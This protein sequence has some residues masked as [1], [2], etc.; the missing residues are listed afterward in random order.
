MK[1]LGKEG[2]FVQG[3]AAEEP[4]LWLV[5]TGC[6]VTMLSLEVYNQ[7]PR[8]D[9]PALSPFYGNLITGNGSVMEVAGQT[10]MRIAVDGLELEHDII[11]ADTDNQG[12]LGL[13]FM[14]QHDAVIN[15][16]GGKLTIG[17]RVVAAECKQV[18]RSASRVTLAETV[19]VPAGHRM[20]LPG[21]IGGGVLAEGQ[22]MIGPL[23][24]TPGNKAIA[25]A[26]TL[27]DG[28]KNKVPFE[29]MNP[30]TEDILLYKG[31]HVALA[32]PAE[33]V[34]DVQP[35]GFEKTVTSERMN[36]VGLTAELPPELGRMVDEIGDSVSQGEKRAI[37]QMLHRKRS[38][39]ML[40]G[41]PLGK[42]D[43]VHHEIH[44]TTQ[45]PIKQPARRFPIHQREEGEKQVKEM[46]EK[47]LIEPSESPWASPV[48]LVKKKDGSTRF[49]IDYRRLNDV[50][51]KD[52]YPLPRIDD[53]LDALSGAD[54]FSTLDLASGYWQVGLAD[55]ARQK[56][57]FVTNSGLYQFTVMPFGLSNAPST[58]ERLMERVLSGLQWQICL[59]YLDDVIVFSR[60]VSQ[61]ISRLEEVLE[62]IMAA[63]LRLKP[64]KCHLFQTRVGYLGHVVSGEGISTDPE[65]IKA[66]EDW[67]VPK[68]LHDV[69]SFLGLCS[70]Y[71][72]FI[73]D[74]SSIAKPLTQL[75]EKERDFVWGTAQEEAWLDL[76]RR[77]V[78]APILAYPDPQLSFILDTDASG[79]GIGGVL[80]QVQDG[81]ER[82]IAYGSRT[83]TKEERRYCV[84]RRELLSVVYF[85]K[86]FR[87]YLY[88]RKFL[89]RTD[90]GALRWLLNFKDP[91]GQVARW[92]EVLDTYHFDIQHR[93]GVRHG[94]ADALSRGPCRQ[95]GRE[96][97]V[98]VQT[99]VVTRAQARKE[100]SQKP[101][102]DPAPSRVIIPWIGAGSLHLDSI[103]RA[104]HKDPVLSQLFAW[105]QQG[106]RPAWGDVSAA[107][108]SLKAYWAQWESV[109]E[110]DGVLYR[111]FVLEGKKTR[112]QILV[113]TS[114]QGEVFAQLHAAVTGGH[115]GVRRTLANIR[116]R[117]YWVKLKEDVMDRCRRCSSCA[118]RKPPT[119]KKKAPLK[120]Y[121]MGLPLER[122]ALDIL[123]PLPLTAQGNR[124]VLV[125]SDYFT[126]WVE[127]VALPDQE[128]KTT[129][130]AFV[131]HFVT[132]FGVPM[133]L[134]T[135]QGR[136][137]ESKLFKEMGRLLGVKKT[138]TTAYRPQSDGLVERFNRT[139]ATMVT[140]YASEHQRTW[141]KYL[142]MLTMAYR[143]TPHESSGLSPNQLMFGREINLPVDIMIGRPPVTEEVDQHE[144]AAELRERLEDAYAQARENLEHAAE[145][146][147]LYYDVKTSGGHYKPGDAVWMLNKDRR[148]GVCP[149]LQKRWKGPALV[150][151]R[152]NDVTYRLRLTPESRK[153]THFDLLKPYTDDDLPAWMGPIRQK[154]RERR[155][156][157]AEEDGAP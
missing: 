148:K 134:H 98:Q 86:Q 21:R 47:G 104:Q 18:Q 157:D 88:G 57:A 45:V 35:L 37:K 26:R 59:V 82:V 42:T 7:I 140:A 99:K 69:R 156:P 118:A 84:T 79:F 132:K 64:K 23:S 44:T 30:T 54:C 139:L 46:L 130:D 29:V 6:T 25:V 124:Y 9:R 137:F 58:F 151:E 32:F 60:G 14:L 125:M 113:P 8:K 68:D 36:R 65:K 90:H 105:K 119:K 11:V 115:M 117:F 38:A 3:H 20:L 66:V 91:Q 110:E 135:D 128:A 103:R 107:G 12:M 53:S 126:K 108:L 114:L 39:F 101:A 34:D 19:V 51:I 76:K 73:K 147:K 31:T 55:D 87:H 62:R 70:Y 95:C 41:D 127:A 146:Q 80:S 142:P 1:N 141:D 92:I 155:R 136:N 5:D 50:T 106:C 22:W 122:V 121:V 94:N 96:D 17:R 27:V 33:V 40:E 81:E 112:R 93:P 120:K 150:E 77:L 78:N 144:Y 4:V 138:R 97:E 10:R 71:R 15:V 143:S 109:R 61:H 2:L 100:E 123:G 154:L 16:A 75:T 152:L 89:V 74:F 133:F 67:K 149:K 83:L 24:H 28:Q 56:S 102:E 63:G 48:V 13:D 129:A 111:E 72:R 145:R 85:V 131:T 43:L 52:A 116:A 153:V 49:C